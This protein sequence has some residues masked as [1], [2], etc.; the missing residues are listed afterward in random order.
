MMNLQFISSL[1]AGSAPS[2]L[3]IFTLTRPLKIGW[4]RP[5]VKHIHLFMAN[6]LRPV[7][8]RR[9]SSS[10]LPISGGPAAA[11]QWQA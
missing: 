2:L 9:C 11:G 7:A 3:S 1:D 5:E 10:L 6:V 8:I 4:S